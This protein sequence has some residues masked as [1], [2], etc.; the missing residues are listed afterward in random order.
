MTEYIEVLKEMELFQGISNSQIP[1]LLSC[2]SIGVR[3]Y[4]KGE[5]IF[6][7]H[8]KL[9]HIGIMLSGDA[10]VIQDDFF[11]NRNIMANLEAGNLFGES[12]AF[13]LIPITTINVL[14][15]SDCRILFI[16][17]Q[18]L[19]APCRTGCDFHLLLIRNML[20]IV[21]MKNILL[22]E[23]IELLS[24]RSLREKLLSYLSTASAKMG[25]TSF[26]IPFNRQE[27]ADY[28]CVDRS[29]LSAEL[30]KLKKEGIL[31]YRKNYFELL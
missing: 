2:L 22:T 5:T 17:S 16:D 19:S 26:T 8:E 25:N 1:T 12:F 18:K 7:N 20:H 27:L 3:S 4:K 30:S 21:S 31:N 13:S 10:Q 23:K 24:R 29:A 15:T 6:H 9:H 28:L 14:A 11:G